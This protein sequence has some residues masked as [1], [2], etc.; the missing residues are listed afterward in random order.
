MRKLILINVLVLISLS[1]IAQDGKFNQ[2]DA[3]GRKQGTWMKYYEP[4]EKGKEQVRYE[5]QF[6]NDKPVGTFFYYY[7]TGEK[8]SE[9]SYIGEDGVQSD[10]KFFHVNG[11]V[12]GEGKYLNQKKDGVWKYYDDQTILSSVEP[13]KAGKL[14]GVVKVYFLNGKVAAEIPYV[15]GLKN[16]PFVEYF[17]DGSVRM[18]GTYQD[19]TYTGEYVQNFPT[20]KPMIKGQYTAAVKDGLWIYYADDGRVKAQQVFKKGKMI[21]EKIEDGFEPTEVPID[22]EEKDKIDEQKLLDEYYKQTEMGK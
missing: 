3:Q 8:S 5:G 9:V 13:Y 20:G 16:G 21:K 7:Q 14:E 15:N 19:N 2:T 6:K 12:M 11:T 22:I 18:Q 17:S 4:D 10:A 1:I